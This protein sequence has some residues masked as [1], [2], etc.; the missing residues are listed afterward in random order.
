MILV[1]SQTFEELAHNGLA[2]AHN[3]AQFLFRLAPLV[4]ACGLLRRQPM[5]T[6]AKLLE[7]FLVLSISQHSGLETNADPLASVH[8]PLAGA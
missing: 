1:S 8:P 2:T 6:F 5:E 4:A 3:S 7:G